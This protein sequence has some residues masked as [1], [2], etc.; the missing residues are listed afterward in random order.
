MFCKVY[1]IYFQSK[2]SG[3]LR[4]I[5][6]VVIKWMSR[7]C[8]SPKRRDKI[9]YMWQMGEIHKI[10]TLLLFV[11]FWIVCVSNDVVR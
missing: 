4:P 3:S 10:F 6:L 8:V 1:N 5:F 2:M 11:N 9:K 7:V